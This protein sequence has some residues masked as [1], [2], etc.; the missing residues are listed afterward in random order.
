MIRA[1]KG[2]AEKRATPEK[3]AHKVTKVLQ[4]QKGLKENAESKGLSVL[5]GCKA[6][7]A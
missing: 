6:F 3:P 4:A 5:V 7:R 1:T 2:I